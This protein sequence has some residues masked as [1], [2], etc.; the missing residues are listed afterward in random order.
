MVC[1]GDDGMTSI[2]PWHHLHITHKNRSEVA[3]WYA[4]HLGARLGKGTP[5]SENLWYGNNLVQVQSDT[6]I[7]PPHTG[8]F[9][10]AGLAF[11]DIAQVK[12]AAVDAGATAISDD[13]I[14][15]PWGTRI[16]LVE[17]EA[18]G[19][20]HLLILCSDPAE[21]SRW[22]ADHIGGQVETCPW[23]S[24]YLSIKY[25]TMWLVFGAGK[26]PEDRQ[27]TGRPID[28]IGWYTSDIAKTTDAMIEKGCRFPVPVRDFGAVQLA[29]A[30]DPSGIWVEFVE[31]PDGKLPK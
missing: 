23:N 27:E 18:I 8:E 19:F 17:S 7:K 24:E 25:D 2:L 6:A 5:R 29:F 3:A 16:Q 1:I 31:P 11:P 22:Y 9:D 15:D 13:M 14:V 21:S 28:H 20:H 30:E 10:H 12:K 26:L 4:R